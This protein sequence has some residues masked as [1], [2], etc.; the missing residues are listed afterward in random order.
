[1]NTTGNAPPAKV[2]QLTAV[3]VL[4]GFMAGLDTSLVNVGLATIAKDLHTALTSV[5]WITSGYLLALAAALPA[6]PWLQRR[7]GASACG[8]SA[9][10]PSRPR[11]C[12]ARPRRTCPC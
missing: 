2:A 12:C 3:I 7:L 6:C 1:M 5:Q 8:W 4:G 9:S 10:S 11:R